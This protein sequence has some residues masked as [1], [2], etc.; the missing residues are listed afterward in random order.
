M[1]HVTDVILIDSGINEKRFF[2]DIDT[3]F[4]VRYNSS[5]HRLDKEAGGNEVMQ[6]DVYMGAFN[7][8]DIE[9]FIEFF[10]FLKW[11]DH[12]GIQLLIKDEH[13]DGFTL[14]YFK[15]GAYLEGK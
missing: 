4:Q 13:D 7:Y 3:W 8:M 6:C 15:N 1:S 11:N 10:N 14:R 12:E 2:R 9:E 5:L